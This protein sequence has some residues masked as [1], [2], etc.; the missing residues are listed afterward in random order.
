M[1]PL[2]SLVIIGKNS[3]P[4]LKRAID[5][6][7]SQE[8]PPS[9]EII[10]V[11]GHS[12]D[13]SKAIVDSY[14]KAGHPIAFL[15]DEI[16]SDNGGRLAGAKSAKGKYLAFLDADD[17]LAPDFFKTMC[18]VMKDTGADIVS[19][20]FYS[21]HH[22]GS[23]FPACSPIRRSLGR[24]QAVRALFKD[25]SLRGFLWGKMYKRELFIEADPKLLAR[26]VYAEDQSVFLQVLLHAGKL[27]LIPAHLVYYNRCNAASGTAND[28][29]RRVREHLTAMSLMRKA[30]DLS[31][32]GKL[33][34]IWREHA[35][36]RRM[37]IDHDLR[38]T[39]KALGKGLAAERTKAYEDL[40]FLNGDEPL[41]FKGTAFEPDI[42]EAFRD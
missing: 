29:P 25:L 31:G 17:W 13:D 9:Y 33:L 39:R 7:L 41:D 24:Y 10:Y 30:V 22:H 2:V 28:K 36:W 32:D 18:R 20:S 12:S 14:M 34:R 40:T 3:A 21:V 5:S 38:K 37:A 6:A 1:P 16:H 42:L 27:V 8:D 19:S 26:T 15:Q 4:T 23:Y 35:P 11:D